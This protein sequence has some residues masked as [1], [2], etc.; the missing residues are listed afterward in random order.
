MAKNIPQLIFG[1][2]LDELE[3]SDLLVLKN[4]HEGWFHD[5]KREMISV[6]DIA[7]QLCSFAN[8]FG[9]ILYFGIQEDNSTLCADTFPGIATADIENEVVR[10]RQAASEH[11]SPIPFFE[12][13]TISGPSAELNL[14]PD[15]SIII[16]LVHEGRDTPYLHSSGHIYHRVHDSSEPVKVTDRFS[17][18]K[19]IQKGE[20]TNKLLEKFIEINSPPLKA[21]SAHFRMFIFGNPTMEPSRLSLNMDEFKDEYLTDGQHEEKNRVFQHLDDGFNTTQYLDPD[22]IEA[23]ESLT[24]WKKGNALIELDLG[25][26]DGL[27]LRTSIND[28]PYLYKC[29]YETEASTYNGFNLDVIDL[30]YL[31]IVIHERLGLVVRLLKK[32][33]P[34]IR[35]LLVYMEIQNVGNTS[36]YVDSECFLEHIRDNGLPI[37]RRPKI[38][39]PLRIKQQDMITVTLVDPTD[40]NKNIDYLSTARLFDHLSRSLGYSIL[41]HPDSIKAIFRPLIGVDEND[42]SDN[43]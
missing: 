5:Y 17:I 33:T 38:Q 10:I 7:K 1:K 30:N 27:K 36:P 4:K 31:G 21:K 42:K 34:K 24:F 43:S 23:I 37:N 16:A 18:D 40:D 12:L 39:L 32:I 3:A 19:L 6:K 8:Q 9:G 35:E 2:H 15:R 22:N 29:E 11:C 41:N 28:T 13:H 25:R 14:Q 20:E 26:G